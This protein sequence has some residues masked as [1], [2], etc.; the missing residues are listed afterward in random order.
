MTDFQIW[1][2]FICFGNSKYSCTFSQKKKKLLANGNCLSG[3]SFSTDF[4]E[5]FSK[6]GLELMLFF[7]NLIKTSLHVSQTALLQFA[8]VFYT[9]PSATPSPWGTSWGGG[10][11]EQRPPSP[12]RQ[13]TER[14]KLRYS[15]TFLPHFPDT[16]EMIPHTPALPYSPL[17]PFQ[18]LPYLVNEC[19]LQG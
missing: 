6:T 10:R 7:Q 8:K 17:S 11:K 3:V 4:P 14:G 9:S 1:G 5:Y 15:P 12:L 18:L 13:S 19:S 16:I 2:W